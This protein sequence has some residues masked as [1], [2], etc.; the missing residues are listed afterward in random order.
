MPELPK[1]DPFWKRMQAIWDARRAAG[2]LPR[3]EQQ[4]EEEREQMRREWDERLGQ[5]QEDTA[6]GHSGDES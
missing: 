6:N 3:S 4:V 5:G 1:D 2:L